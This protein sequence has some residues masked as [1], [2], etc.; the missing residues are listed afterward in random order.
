MEL[1]SGAHI[2]L[3][4]SSVIQSWLSELVGVSTGATRPVG[5]VD[6]RVAALSGAKGRS[7]SPLLHSSLE[8]MSVE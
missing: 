6:S 5:L 4:V 2:N 8:K 7:S 1:K 3:L